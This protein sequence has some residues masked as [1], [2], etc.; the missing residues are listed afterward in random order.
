[1]SDP[2]GATAT[3]SV[4]YPDGETPQMAELGLKLRQL[5]HSEG[6]AHLVL[7]DRDIPKVVLD[8]DAPPGAE[9]TAVSP[10]SRAH[11]RAGRQ[12][13]YILEEL[14]PDFAELRTGALIRTVLRVPEGAVLYYLVEPG[15]HLY[16]ATAALDRLN[17][18]DS[19]MAEC[20]NRLRA[21]VR[22]SPLNYGAWFGDDVWTGKPATEDFPPASTTEPADPSSAYV[23][24]DVTGAARIPAGTEEIL[25]AA[26]DVDGL[27]YVAYY[28][29][30]ASVC[31]ADLFNHPVLG[32]YFLSRSPDQRRD[33]YGRMGR[34]LP[35][36][37]RRMNMS[38]RTVLR[39]EVLQVVLDV[40]QGAV[41]FHT[42]PGGRFL[43][44][45]TLDQARVT[46]ADHRIVRL[47][48][49]LTGD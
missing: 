36:I 45:V 3:G 28:T 11:E 48:R 33:K 21:D 44:G 2:S 38:L 46:E 15:F 23:F 1:M 16:G 35:G 5:L 42:L 43:V 29:D 7:Y 19:R 40:E 20:V 4:R 49:E 30:P 34:L 31:T 13:Y 8:A 17:E 47:G 25:R 27:H 24:G 12:L 18:L 10:Q 32:R 26:L 41:Y 22:Y 37:T 9:K 14:A 6:L 39:G